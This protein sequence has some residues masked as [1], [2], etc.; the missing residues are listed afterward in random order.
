MILKDS[1]SFFLE[2]KTTQKLLL[3]IIEVIGPVALLTKLEIVKLKLFIFLR[4]NF[5]IVLA[6]IFITES[7]K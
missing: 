7:L 3:A 6:P 2:N 4:T 1:F 5:S